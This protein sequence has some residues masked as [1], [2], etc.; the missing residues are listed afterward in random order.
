MQIMQKGIRTSS[1]KYHLNAKPIAASVEA[2]VEASVDISL[3]PSTRTHTQPTLNQMA[4]FRARITKSTFEKINNVLLL[5]L[6]YS[7]II[8]WYTKI[9]VKKIASH[10]SQ[11]KYCD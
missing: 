9:H 4:G 2:S 11:V 10:C 7:V 5:K 1:L 8:Q 3:S 6:M